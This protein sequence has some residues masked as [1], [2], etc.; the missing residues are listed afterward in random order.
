MSSLPIFL[1]LEPLIWVPLVRRVQVDG[2]EAEV[3][4]SQED[5]RTRVRLQLP[6]DA[7]RE[8]VLEA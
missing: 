7:A 4:L 2:Q 6:L 1:I 5:D 8:I 3:S